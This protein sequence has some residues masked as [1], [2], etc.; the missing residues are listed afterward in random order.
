MRGGRRPSS[1]L[2]RVT[3]GGHQMGTMHAKAE[4]FTVVGFRR[5]STAWRRSCAVEGKRK[6]KHTLSTQD[7][8]PTRTTDQTNSDRPKLQPTH[9]TDMSVTARQTQ[10]QTLPLCRSRYPPNSAVRR[11]PWPKRSQAI[12][13]THGHTLCMH[14]TCVLNLITQSLSQRTANP[15]GRRI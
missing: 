6:P 10:R 5:L 14:V 9:V 11:L 2:V 15:P 4:R 7:S 8:E 1:L 3:M 13:R 12:P